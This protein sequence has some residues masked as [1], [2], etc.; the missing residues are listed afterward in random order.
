LTIHCKEN[1][2]R[3]FTLC[4]RKRISRIRGFYSAWPGTTVSI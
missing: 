2:E 3:L 4:T 1:G